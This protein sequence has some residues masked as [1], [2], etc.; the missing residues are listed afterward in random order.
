MF[1]N[2]KDDD[3][4]VI[5]EE[6]VTYETPADSADPAGSAESPALSDQTVA[7]QSDSTDA[8]AARTP[9]D[10]TGRFGTAATPGDAAAAPAAD[11]DPQP[12]G[13]DGNGSFGSGRDDSAVDD[14]AVDSAVDDPASGEDPAVA[15]ATAGNG[16]YAATAGNGSYAATASTG[17]YGATAEA[18]GDTGLT[19]ADAP[20]A[21]DA[22]GGADDTGLA[23]AA[24]PGYGTDPA[25]SAADGAYGTAN[26]H[27]RGQAIPVPDTAPAAVAAPADSPAGTPASPASPAATAATSAA[28]PAADDSSWPQIQS[29]FVDD[30]QSAV[31]QAAD[32]AGGALAALVAA[33]KNR[34]QSMRD[35]WQSDSTGT[36]DLRTA[37]R[38]YRDLAGRLSALSR[39]L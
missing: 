26:G 27:G 30:P 6:D 7:D 20:D 13:T 5:S 11:A 17:S 9:S 35:A 24:R 37:L 12:V 10:A 39:D 32:V 33:A 31:R 34:E 4:I 15:P 22:A 29:L 16:S 14:S 36:E 28:A 1:N 38:G 23:D 19:S 25:T 8:D 18:P 21:A 3:V 2:R